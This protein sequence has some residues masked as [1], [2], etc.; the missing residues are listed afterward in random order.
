MG[1]SAAHRE[2]VR[3]ARL[4]S[5]DVTGPP[6]PPKNAVPSVLKSATRHRRY[7]NAGPNQTPASMV[8]S[9]PVAHGNHNMAAAGS[10]LPLKDEVKH[11]LVRNTLALGGGG[12]APSAMPAW[13]SPRASPEP[14]KLGS[15]TMGRE[16]LPSPVSK[17]ASPVSF[18]GLEQ[19]PPSPGLSRPEEAM[20]ED[21][22][23]ASPM[24]RRSPMPR[25][26]M[27][28]NEGLPSPASPSISPTPCKLV[29]DTPRKEQ[30]RLAQAD[31]QERLPPPPVLA[32]ETLPSPGRSHGMPGR[33]PVPSPASSVTQGNASE[34]LLAP[35]KLSAR[36]EPVRTD[37]MAGASE[38]LRRPASP[39]A[40]PAK[41]YV[42][43]LVSK[44]GDKFV[45]SS[46][47][48]SSPGRPCRTPEDESV[49]SPAMASVSA[50]AVKRC[51]ALTLPGNPVPIEE[52]D[53]CRRDVTVGA[54]ERLPTPFCMSTSPR[55]PR[56]VLEPLPSSP[57]PHCADSSECLLSPASTSEP[58][59][60]RHV[61]FEKPSSP[62]KL[63]RNH[64]CQSLQSPVSASSP[65]QV[66]SLSGTSPG[67][68]CSGLLSPTSAS[69]SPPPKHVALES[70]T[71]KSAQGPQAYCTCKTSSSPASESASASP[72]KQ[73]DVVQ[74]CGSP[75]KGCL[76]KPAKVGCE[77]SLVEADGSP[78][79]RVDK[80][81]TSDSPKK[82]RRA[83]AG[84]VAEEVPDRLGCKSTSPRRRRGK[85]LT[86]RGSVSP[87]RLRRVL[88][89]HFPS[90]SPSA[91]ERSQQGLNSDLPTGNDG[92]LALGTLALPDRSDGDP[93]CSECKPAS[94]TTGC[95][96]ATGCDQQTSQGQDIS[97]VLCTT[98]SASP[99][100]TPM[101]PRGRPQKAAAFSV[102]LQLAA[103]SPPS[104]IVHPEVC[105]TNEVAME[106]GTS[107]SSDCATAAGTASTEQ[108]SSC[109]PTLPIAKRNGGLG[110]LASAPPSAVNLSVGEEGHDECSPFALTDLRSRLTARFASIDVA[111]HHL[112]RVLADRRGA[113]EG[114][115]RGRTGPGTHRSSSSSS[116][117]SGSSS[118]SSSRS[119]SSSSTHSS[120]RSSALGGFTELLRH[121][122]V[123]GLVRAFGTTAAQAESFFHAMDTGRAE[124]VALK[125]LAKVLA[126]CPPGPLLRHLRQRL[127]EKHKSVF[128]AFQDPAFSCFSDSGQ[129][130]R[131]A[132][133]QVL[134]ILT[135]V[136]DSET[137]AL[138]AGLASAL[139]TLPTLEDVRAALRNTAPWCTLSG[140]FGRL[141]AF[142]GEGPRDVA[143]LRRVLVRAGG[144][145]EEASA[146]REESGGVADGGL[147]R[148]PPPGGPAL[149]TREAFDRVC[150]M[151]DLAS[152][153][154]AQI[155]EVVFGCRCLGVPL[156]EFIEQGA[157]AG[158][159]SPAGATAPAAAAL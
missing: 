42:G 133:A 34:P 110:G 140:F 156:E 11:E 16:R 88:F 134:G 3:V 24:P 152:E 71:G 64:G 58:Q 118:S 125:D 155:W 68:G 158:G 62:L 46:P 73:R 151:L 126:T 89:T 47:S 80:T 54:S 33:E 104:D 65:T 50:P 8:A 107:Y 30:R 101:R 136:S 44:C 120:P 128:D 87:A 26:P 148:G 43:L 2:A 144:D 142:A 48:T 113:H 17:P 154:G 14:S 157:A 1:R 116:T 86:C 99:P 137:D 40:I 76:K 119:S 95:P 72:A 83:S 6:A 129:L 105:G 59:Q 74:Q 150:F 36:L 75:R 67:L 69:A 84:G 56:A 49:S 82:R 27:Q 35:Q 45:Q 112:G 12:K 143:A 52:E 91:E 41:H 78:K 13:T 124:V 70:S 138:Y 117:S 130:T 66:W 9:D 149:I 7:K 85:V 55:K 21:L 115:D 22:K 51:L 60:R 94:P 159:A 106:V 31:G 15:A 141:W 4:A 10:A 20:R 32:L 139:G 93:D 132:F 111:V 127:I 37:A 153:N 53:Q 109:K 102:V 123:D 122:F 131:S 96:H 77:A 146:V 90:S 97:Q 39:A 145:D 5:G 38:H 25:S 108:G 28:P 103:L 19:L 29:P 147:G 23:S 100:A 135:A 57:K 121:D 18:K 98:T 92:S 114:F 63:G 79:R 61:D 81:P